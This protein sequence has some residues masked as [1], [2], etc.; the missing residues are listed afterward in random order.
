[1][2]REDLLNLLKSKKHLQVALDFI[3]INDAIR[4]ADSARKGGADIIEAGTPLVKAEGIHG[5]LTLRENHKDAILLADT[6]TAD[7]G[8]VEAVI[9][10]KG[11]ANIMTVLGLMDD[12]TIESA[13]KKAKEL[14]LLV[15]VDLINIKEPIERAKEINE[16]GAD[17]VGLHVGLDVQKSRGITITSLKDEIREIGKYS[18]VSVAGGINEKNVIDLVD[19]PISIYVVG[20]AI[21]KN[22]NPTEVT[23]HIV[24][25]INGNTNNKGD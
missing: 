3:N 22:Q 1:M 17:I 13:V 11:G 9:A 24:N 20:G 25:I 7:A 5:L 15:Q 6:K 14:N 23:K 2:R 10:Y 12:S 21:T 18:I 4:V 8:D 19:L 16:L